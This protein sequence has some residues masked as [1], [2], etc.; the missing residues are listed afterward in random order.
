LVEWLTEASSEEL[1]RLVSRDEFFWLDLTAPSPGD[2]QVLVD[3]IGLDPEAAERALDFDRTPQ[4]HPFSD[5]VG[6]VFYGGE[7]RRLLEVHVFV[8]GGWVVTLH[9]QPSKSLD[10][11][12][13]DLSQG[14]PPAEESVVGSVLNALAGSFDDLIDPYDE[15]I[16]RIESQAVAVEEGRAEAGGLRREILQRRSRALHSLRIVRRQRDYIDR[17]VGELSDLPGL[18]PSQH[19]ELRDVTT[20]MIRVAD[21]IDDALNRLAGALD[22][23]NS[24]V[25]N[26]TNMVIQ[27]LTVVATIFLPLTALTGFFGMNFGWMVTHIT[28]FGAFLGLGVVLIAASGLGTYIWVRSRLERS[29][30]G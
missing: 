20:Q 24:S 13:E 16:E 27:R 22:L 4:L 8:S 25:A 18:E 21:S 9:E 14:E 10:D 2:V 11:L 6:M 7:S 30:S 26:R 17:A 23:L 28:S 15:E 12:R 1:K 19:H 29:T 3:E 5:H